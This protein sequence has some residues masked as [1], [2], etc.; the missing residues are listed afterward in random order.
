[1]GIGN[2]YYN[3]CN[4]FSIFYR[5]GENAA[6]QGLGGST[7]LTRKK[8]WYIKGE[9]SVPSGK[10][11]VK[12]QGYP[13]I[14]YKHSEFTY[15]ENCNAIIAMQTVGFRCST[16]CSSCAALAGP[17]GSAES[18]RCWAPLFPCLSFPSKNV[19]HSWSRRRRSRAFLRSTRMC[20]STLLSKARVNSRIRTVLLPQFIASSSVRFR[21]SP[22]SRVG[23][24]SASKSRS[25]MSS[26][27]RCHSS[28]Q[29]RGI[30]MPRMDSPLLRRLAKT[31]PE[32]CH[33]VVMCSDTR[34]LQY[35]VHTLHVG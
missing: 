5:S 21:S 16:R 35:W 8:F 30:S 29:S 3:A 32:Q 13:E 10:N 2:V 4:F 33:Q 12:I 24:P 19:R 14:T 18:G 23:S 25:N 6:S 20:Q 15:K 34:I 26:I 28:R 22:T 9:N 27:A 1:M 7:I 11:P 31:T 17:A